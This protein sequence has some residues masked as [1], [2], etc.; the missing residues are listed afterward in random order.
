MW[1]HHLQHRTTTLQYV[2]LNTKYLY[3]YNTSNLLYSSHYRLKSTINYDSTMHILLR[4]YFYKHKR[5]LIT[6]IDHGLNPASC[7]TFQL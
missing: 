7:Y 2:I 5:L 4:A 1:C 3:S 6:I